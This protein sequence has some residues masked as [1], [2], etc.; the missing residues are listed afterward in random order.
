[1][2]DINR[3]VSTIRVYLNAKISTRPAVVVHVVYQCNANLNSKHLVTHPIQP[4]RCLL[5]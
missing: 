5:N 3:S 1:M 2:A 4:L